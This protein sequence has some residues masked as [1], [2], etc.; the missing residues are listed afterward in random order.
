MERHPRTIP[1][2]VSANVEKIS[3]LQARVDAD[4]W[5]T[6]AWEAMAAEVAGRATSA[7]AL[8][9][10]RAVYDR[11]LKQF[12]TAAR[13]WR[14][15]AEA[16]MA[17]GNTAQVKTVFSRCLLN[18]LTVDL[19]A[20]YL[21][22]IKKTNSTKGA[23]GMIEMRKAFEYTLDKV[24]SDLHSQP[25]WLDF[26]NFL[27][28]P[29]AGTPGY[30][31]LFAV[32]NAV[33]QEE[34]QRT[35]M[36]RRA[37]Q[38][39]LMVPMD[40]LD[41]VWR[42]Y[43]QFEMATNATLGRRVL[44]DF[45]PKYQAAR[46]AYWDRKKH[47][48]VVNVKALAV[49]PGKGG[50]GQQQQMLMWKDYLAWEQSNRQRLEGPQLTARVTLA[51]DQA[52]IPLLHY[53]EIWYGYARWH[54]LG[55]GGGIMAAKAVFSRA[56]KAL[57][58]CVMLH[59]AAA[60]MEEVRGEVGAATAVYEEL[61]AGLGSSPPQE[62]PSDGQPAKTVQ[63]WA[64]YGSLIWIQYMRFA[65]RAKDLKSSRQI[66]M[67]ARKWDKCGWQVYVATALMEWHTSRNDTP[68]RKIFELGLQAGFMS[69]PQYVLQYIEFLMG[70]G[71]ATNARA[72]FER[73]LAEVPAGSGAVLWDRYVRFEYEN[74]DMAAVTAIEARRAEALGGDL[75]PDKE[76]MHLML[77]RTKVLDLWPCTPSQR[78]HLERLVGLAPA[79]APPPA[80]LYPPQPAQPAGPAD[81][82]P[83][84]EGGSG[85]GPAYPKLEGPPMASPG[86]SPRHVGAPVGAAG[87]AGP[88]PVGVPRQALASPVHDPGEVQPLK[89]LPVE[90]GNFINALP[91]PQSLTGALPSVDSVVDVLLKADF[92]PAAAAAA[93]SAARRRLRSATGPG[94]HPRGPHPDAGYQ[95]G[96]PPPQQGP[97]AYQQPMGGAPGP[98]G[99]MPA[100]GVDGGAYA[101]Q[102]RKLDEFGE[103]GPGSGNAQMGAPANGYTDSQQPAHD[104]YRQRLSQ[105][106]KLAGSDG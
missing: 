97:P 10:Q 56:R 51:F 36:V 29:K 47:L 18:C 12:P 77:L 2:F 83:G 22:F 84:I 58:A 38:R 94:P 44:D 40:K 48:E 23:D 69:E 3:A 4:P 99:G 65:K 68:P 37:Y 89:Q 101:G 15:Y 106:S 85:P 80:A 41:P 95:Q 30:I 34:A 28:A 31:T 100:G 52:L 1:Q 73:A 39:A 105:R 57:P 6:A 64:Q 78:S 53:P 27:Q 102:K 13:Y 14:L 70:L 88:A 81:Y 74:G 24:G 62:A 43:E 104:M 60:D 61:V 5:D 76:N 63:P 72:L 49:P 21:E 67:R 71:D 59:F 54:Q 17:A 86:P 92:S 98:Q 103:G 45:R 42:G 9:E 26:I 33:G 50:Y 82:P 11:L 90:L 35:S 66:F 91:P 7:A 32:P 46:S 75:D 96:L 93:E 55:P 20:T 8:E 79:I 19:W 25:L 87:P 16:E